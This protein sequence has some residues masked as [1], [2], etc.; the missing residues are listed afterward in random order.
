MFALGV[1][2]FFSIWE[3]LTAADNDIVK[4]RHL[5]EAVG[6]WQVLPSLELVTYLSLGTEKIT[7]VTP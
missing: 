4:G 6:R 2:C 1:L 7:A 5:Q 3:L